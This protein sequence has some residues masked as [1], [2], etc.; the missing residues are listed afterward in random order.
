MSATESNKNMAWRGTN[1]GTQ[2]KKAGDSG[3]E[4][5]MTGVMRGGVLSV[6]NDSVKQTYFWSSRQKI[7]DHSMAWKLALDLSKPKVFYG[8]TYETDA[9]SV[10]CIK[11]N[12]VMKAGGINYN[13]VI[14]GGQ[15][16]TSENMRHGTNSALSAVSLELAPL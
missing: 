8:T 3:F 15:V 9:A 14:I 16:W 7:S 11:N 10:R 1:Q 6:F 13:S 4:A 5:I 2:L 12:E